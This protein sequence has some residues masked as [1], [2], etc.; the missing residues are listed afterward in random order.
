M[1]KPCRH[2]EKRVRLR[3]HPRGKQEADPNEQVQATSSSK[4]ATVWGKSVLGMRRDVES[5]EASGS[6]WAS[7]GSRQGRGG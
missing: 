1:L 5:S 4:E 3:G 6:S 7:A 2:G